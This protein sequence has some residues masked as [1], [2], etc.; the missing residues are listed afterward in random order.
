MGFTPRA[1][2]NEIEARSSLEVIGRQVQSARGAG[3]GVGV[4]CKTKTKKKLGNNPVK[5]QSG[6]E[7]SSGVA[8]WYLT[9]WANVSW[10]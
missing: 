4:S 8:G 1:G 10:R 9:N 5:P 7:A 6:T 3:R 2:G